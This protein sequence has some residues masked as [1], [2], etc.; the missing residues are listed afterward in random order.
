MV[1]LSC[2]LSKEINE[3]TKKKLILKNIDF[4]LFFIFSNQCRTF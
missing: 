4:N 2:I 1:T 3:T